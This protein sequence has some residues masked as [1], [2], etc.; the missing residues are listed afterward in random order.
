MKLLFFFIYKRKKN[1]IKLPVEWL[2]SGGR[3]KSFVLLG[4]ETSGNFGKKGV[5]GRLNIL[6]IAIK[7]YDPG[8]CKM[9]KKQ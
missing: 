9:E 4:V 2:G 3:P 6:A 8:N 1:I 5:Y 7:S